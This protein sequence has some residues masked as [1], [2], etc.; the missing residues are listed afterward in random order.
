[1]AS[2]MPERDKD[3]LN[4]ERYEISPAKGL[5]A[6]CSATSEWPNICSHGES[7]GGREPT[8]PSATCAPPISGV[9][10]DSSCETGRCDRRRRGLHQG[11]AQRPG[12]DS[13]RIDVPVFLYIG[14]AR[15]AGLLCRNLREAR[16]LA[17]GVVRLVDPAVTPGTQTPCCQGRVF[18]TQRAPC[19]RP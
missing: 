9:I 1:V 4:Y 8:W 15:P 6:P 16:R 13:A 14:S 10:S 18:L 2:L 19:A 11:G 7:R 3:K 17:T 5:P 12:T